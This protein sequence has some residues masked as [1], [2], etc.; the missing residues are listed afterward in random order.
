MKFILKV[1]L[2]IYHLWGFGNFS[3]AKLQTHIFK[4][5]VPLLDTFILCI[6]LITLFLVIISL[7]NQCY[8]LFLLLNFLWDIFKFMFKFLV[9]ICSPS[10]TQNISY[11]IKETSLNTGLID[12]IILLWKCPLRNSVDWSVAKLHTHI[13]KWAVPL[14]DTFC[15]YRILNALFCHYIT[16]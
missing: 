9:W 3:V 13:F 7:H 2:P 1:V 4:W 6:T 12:L 14:P 5:A 15:L 16:T 11:Y 10:K 8:I